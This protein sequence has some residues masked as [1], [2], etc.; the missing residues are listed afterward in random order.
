MKDKIAEVMQLLRC[1]IINID[2]DKSIDIT[3]R[4]IRQSESIEEH[5]QAILEL[6]AKELPKEKYEGSIGCDNDRN[7]GYNQCLKDIKHKLGVK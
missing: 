6:I 7:I 2:D 3:E 5:T 4:L 1:D